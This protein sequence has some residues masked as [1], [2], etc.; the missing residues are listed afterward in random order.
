M[1][2]HANY[3]ELIIAQFVYFSVHNIDSYNWKQLFQ[4][5]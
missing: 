4:A 2:R 1:D 5:N 3:L